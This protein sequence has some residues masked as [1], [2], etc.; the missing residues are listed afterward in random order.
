M[1]SEPFKFYFVKLRT[2]SK[3]LS[4]TSLYHFSQDGK[5]VQYLEN[6]GSALCIQNDKL[7]KFVQG[8][9]LIREQHGQQKPKR[10][11]TCSRSG[12]EVARI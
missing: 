12:L 5:K 11:K 4:S 10:K 2:A 7:A 1:L 3:E 8:S 6:R 9:A